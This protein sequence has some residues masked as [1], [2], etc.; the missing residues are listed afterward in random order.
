MAISTAAMRRSGRAI[1]APPGTF[2]NVMTLGNTGLYTPNTSGLA[3]GNV[4]DFIGTPQE[5][6]SMAAGAGRGF[7][8]PGTQPGAGGAGGPRVISLDKNRAI[9]GQIDATLQQLPNRQAENQNAVNRYRKNLAAASGQSQNFA[10][11]ES[12]SLGRVYN[13]ELQGE[14]AGQRQQFQQAS[15]SNIASGAQRFADIRARYG[16]AVGSEI[17]NLSKSLT[18]QLAAYEADIN[19]RIAGEESS[20]AALREQDMAAGRQAA[21]L[22]I[23]QGRRRAVAARAGSGFAGSGAA[24]RSLVLPQLQAE[25]ALAQ[26]G[27]DLSRADYENIASQRRQYGDL[28]AGLR[29]DQIGDIS[30]LR[31]GLAG[32]TTNMEQSAAGWEVGS[33]DSLNRALYE[34]AR[35]DTGY[36]TQLQNAFAGRRRA[37]Q[38][39]PVQDELAGLYAQRDVDRGYIQDLG[40]LSAL[41]KENRFYGIEDPNISSTPNSYYFAPRSSE[42]IGFPQ[43]PPLYPQYEPQVG[44]YDG[45]YGDFGGGEQQPPALSPEEAYRKSVM[46]PNATPA[47]RE[48]YNEWLRQKSRGFRRT[49]PRDFPERPATVNGAQRIATTEENDRYLRDLFGG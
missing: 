11:Q 35:G 28:T 24:L 26:R 16:D 5:R 34:A 15:E 49:I 38:L 42:R 6:A 27:A 37:L 48:A 18:E 4:N 17:E 21:D 30:G 29:R 41:E 1:Y 10:D 2:P 31:R 7:P 3:S 43:P 8:L 23:G 36:L 45:D 9:T 47:Q 19:K 40:S 25:T 44:G 14:L 20:R 39:E 32:E 33:R 12:R 22:A 46:N 13:G